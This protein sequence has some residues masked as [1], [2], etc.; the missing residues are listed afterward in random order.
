MSA[1]TPKESDTVVVVGAVELVV[2]ALALLV[3]ELDVDVEVRWWVV[4]VDDGVHVVE[5]ASDVVVGNTDTV[6][7]PSIHEP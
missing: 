6:M 5:G 1:T 4:L 7:L 2:V 3:V